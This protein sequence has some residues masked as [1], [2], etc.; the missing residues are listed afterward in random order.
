MLSRLR[1]LINSVAPRS[2]ACDA[3]YF[4]KPQANPMSLTKPW[5]YPN[6]NAHVFAM[7]DNAQ[8]A[9]SQ[10]LGTI[11]STSPPTLLDILNAATSRQW[12]IDVYSYATKG[13]LLRHL[14]FKSGTG[15]LL[16]RYPGGFDNDLCERLNASQPTK[17]TVRVI[18]P[19]EGVR[20]HAKLYRLHR[21]D[22]A[23]LTIV[24]SSNATWSGL[25]NNVESNVALFFPKGTPVTPGDPRA[26]F[27]ALWEEG[28]PW[29]ANRFRPTPLIALDAAPLLD[30][31]RHAIQ[32]LE[33]LL[34]RLEEAPQ[35]GKE[36]PGAMLSLP[37]GAGKTVVAV[38]WLL[39]CVLPREEDGH[40]RRV[41][42]L[43]HSEDL[44]EQA[45]LTFRRHLSRE[46]D[47]LRS[48]KLLPEAKKLWWPL[49][50]AHDVVFST[51][52]LA[53][54]HLR[55]V[56][57]RSMEPFD[58]IVIDEAHHVSEAAEQYPEILGSIPHRL[59]LGLS[60][61][62]FP[63]N[64]DTEETLYEYFNPKPIPAPWP[65]F[66]RTFH[67]LQ[68]VI[69]F[70]KKVFAREIRERL[71]TGFTLNLSGVK[72]DIQLKE[73]NRF[74]DEA[75]VKAIAAHYDKKKHKPAL[76][77]AVD[78]SDAN[79]LTRALCKRGV[80]AQAIHTGANV[81]GCL[82]GSPIKGKANVRELKR[83]LTRQE[84]LAAIERLR[85]PDNEL[86]AIVSVDIFIEGLDIP[87]LRSVFLARPTLSPRVF[88]QMRGRGLRGPAMGGTEECRIV[89]CV[90]TVPQGVGSLV[91]NPDRALASEENKGKP[92][93]GGYPERERNRTATQQRESKE[94]PT[95]KNRVG[96]HVLGKKP[97]GVSWETWI[98]M[99]AKRGAALASQTKSV[100]NKKR[101]PAPK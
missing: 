99:E 56:N 71:D 54:N 45:Q 40:Y 72:T 66:H 35:K 81:E 32:S 14:P 1:F 63:M 84:R 89:E 95:P 79:A 83:V 49:A 101:K 17:E 98:Q 57:P 22:G 25:R 43:S 67:Q 38:H 16:L 26:L 52:Q 39:S 92:R 11:T 31:Q 90:D 2:F 34:A 64:H 42:W 36:V 97:P 78:V 8:S 12:P 20:V 80:N 61:T 37:T 60:A 58:V 41:L 23:E 28:V 7:D 55:D 9:L 94:K 53:A 85:D 59:R 88:L 13:Y 47:S 48:L 87:S 19:P 29:D 76:F 62:P 68:G 51:R 5:E 24:G 15:R 93:I 46:V 77:F 27:D 82:Y 4:I 21:E 65:F 91:M 3:I 73:K 70:G 44:L 86:E 10:L 96:A 100:Q 6:G 30:Y 74:D 75:R 50:N 18:E 33:P 69:S